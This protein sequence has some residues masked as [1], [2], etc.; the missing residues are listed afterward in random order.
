MLRHI[1]LR[2][3]AIVHDLDL[4]LSSGMSALT[5]E[6]G[7]GKSIILDA[8]DLA[9]G[10]RANAQVIRHGQEKAEITATFSFET[11]PTAKPWLLDNE[12]DAQ[13]DDII[14]RRI[15]TQEGR[16]KHFINGQVCTQ[17]QAKQLGEL[18]LNI[19]GQHEHQ[20]LTKKDKQRDIL[21]HFAKHNTVLK[22][23]KTLFTTWYTLQETLSSMN[24]NADE[25]QAKIELLEYQVSELRQ[26]NLREGEIP[27]LE[28]EHRLLSHADQLR[29]QVE[30]SLQAIDD[31]NSALPLIYTAQ[32]SLQS[33]AS[34]APRINNSLVLLDN[35]IIQLN[36]ARD[37]LRDYYDTLES[38][39]EKF[40]HLEQRLN[41]LHHLARK[42]RVSP[43]ELMAIQQQL[44]KSLYELK[45]ADEKKLLLEVEVKKSL[46]DYQKTAAALTESRKKSAAILSKKI[47]ES[48]ALLNMKGGQFEIRFTPNEN[49]APSP[50]GNERVEFFVSANIGQPLQPLNMVASGGE[51]SRMSLAI[52]M[53]TAQ[54]EDTPTL[55]FDEVDVGIGGGTAEIIGTL[56]RQL[57]ETTQVI[58]ITHLPQVAAQ[59]HHQYRV[60]K[61]V[62]QNETTT[63]I[64][65]LSPQERVE[66]IARMLGGVTI[67]EQTRKHAQEMLN[68]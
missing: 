4:E 13:S 46:N 37:D 31:E 18:L 17:Q 22:N 7:A 47:T 39:P 30:Q 5:G 10:G 61:V 52:Q 11:I 64:T 24:L 40:F 27:Q 44:E 65:S 66:E 68:S 2:H 60:Q 63:T 19:H 67:T 9:L 14:F 56:L 42:H 3:F 1:T 58:C 62:H 54:K 49:N 38:D 29:Q 48:L 43:E 45:N 36:E 20:Q 28:E 15:V 59:A 55:I 26:L 41:T 32:K 16:S 35:A 34:L 50:F 33:I 8:L 53:I 57:G 6:T 25:K 51:L 23:V 21:D 12:F